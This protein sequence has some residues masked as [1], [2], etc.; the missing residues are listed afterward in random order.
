MLDDAFTT[1]FDTNLPPGTTTGD[2]DAHF[3]S[4]E[5]RYDDRPVHQP[6]APEAPI[7]GRHWYS[8]CSDGFPRVNEA[9]ICDECG[10]IACPICGRED[11][12]DCR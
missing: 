2:I 12:D 9:G 5:D 7:P 10:G 8:S 11:C 6:A 3:G 4:Y 1:S